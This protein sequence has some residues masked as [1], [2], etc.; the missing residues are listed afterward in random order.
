MKQLTSTPFSSI[1]FSSMLMLI[2]CS[3][4]TINV[5]SKS[6]DNIR[7]DLNSNLSSN[8]NSNIKSNTNKNSQH[9]HS[10][11]QA[12][13][14]SDSHSDRVWITIGADV[15]EQS[16]QSLLNQLELN[17][18][19]QDSLQQKNKES[20]VRVASINK[21]NID[22]LSH[23]MHQKFN[24][25]GGFFFHQ[26]KQ[27]AIDFLNS[28][29][30]P[31]LLA[32][33][34]TIDNSAGVNALFSELN[35]SNLDSTVNTLSNYY[36]RYYTKQSGVDASNWIKQQWESISSGRSDISVA[37]YNHSWAQPSV[38]A[39]VTGTT[40]PDEI[41]VIGGHLDS[42]N[43]SNPSN[44]SAPGADDN[45]SGIA[46]LTE[47]LRAMVASGYKPARTIKFMG[48]AAEEVGLRGSNAIAQAHKND[49][50]DVIGVAQFDM[51][52]NQGTASRDIVFMTDYTNSAQNN[53]MMQLLDTYMP[54]INYGTSRCGYGCSDHASWHNQGFAASIPFESNMSDANYRIHTA[55]D[56]VFDS[57]HA[58]NFVKLSSAFVAE[59]G[60]GGT[61]D[62]PP[63]P[64]PPNDD[65]L[66]NGVPINGLNASQGSDVIYTMDV[67][68]GATDISF[69]ISGGSGDADLY[70]K[71][72]SAPTDSSYDCRPYRNGNNETCTGSSNGGTYY[73]RVKAYS[74]F[75]NVSLVGNYTEAGQGNPPINET[76]NDISVNQGQWFYHT[77]DLASGYASL[78]VSISGGSGDGDLYVRRGAQP[79]TSN[80]DCRPY[81]W[82][83]D[84]S[85][86]FNSPAADTWYIG[87]RGYSNSSAITLNI[88]GTP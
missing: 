44:G 38:I 5:D 61:G 2:V 56:T 17:F 75:S 21:H 86:S 57:N 87:V 15:A 1:S 10:F 62:N 42:I 40:N 14:D 13:N 37:L 11:K 3:F 58:Y 45:A 25:C 50:S 83:N 29:G 72:G 49:G 16:K 36:N 46:V 18:L 66:E 51:T 79:S 12:L 84:E 80:Y 26:S 68:S 88:T 27:Q 23:T 41:I 39:T 53:F 64:P 20:N 9:T 74:T 19:P 33:N 63:P 70:V 28:T 52:G 65:V 81:K 7:L 4:L 76:V 6:G 54:G 35:I 47:T 60:K 67:P 31:E 8:L 77:V 78:E 73:I 85:C 43:Q 55:N 71:F 32:V 34:Y 22:K 30:D 48:Y 24:R 69:A 59:L 82:G